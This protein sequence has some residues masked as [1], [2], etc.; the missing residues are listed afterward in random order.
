ML[1]RKR[2]ALKGYNDHCY[3]IARK[4]CANNIVQS[5]TD[6]GH[7]MSERLS[8]INESCLNRKSTRFSL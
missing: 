8:N 7:I 1:T 4:C 2:K 5:G 3:V 6:C